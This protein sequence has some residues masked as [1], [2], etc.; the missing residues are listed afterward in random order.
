MKNGDKLLPPEPPAIVRAVQDRDNGIWKRH[1]DGTGWSVDLNYSSAAPWQA[2]CDYAPLTVVETVEPV[3]IT[4]DMARRG[5]TEYSGQTDP[6]VGHHDFAAGMK[7]AL[8]SAGI[9]C[10]INFDAS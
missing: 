7:V 10:E 2:V 1:P 5:Y 4:E 3:V 9:P 8:E 6:W